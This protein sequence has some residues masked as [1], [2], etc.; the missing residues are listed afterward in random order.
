M[1]SLPGNPYDGHTLEGTLK[2]VKSLTQHQ[3]E[4]V[5]VDL[6]YRGATTT[7]VKVYHRKRKHGITARLS[8]I[9][10]SRSK[11]GLVLN[12]G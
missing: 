3:P 12:S 6:G 8:R 11:L 1:R 5:F 2:Q 7:G 4:E 9:G 10:V